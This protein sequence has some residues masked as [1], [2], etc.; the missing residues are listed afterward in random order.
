LSD[1]QLFG[2]WIQHPNRADGQALLGPEVIVEGAQFGEWALVFE[3]KLEGLDF[4]I[5]TLREIGQGI[6]ADLAVSAVGISQQH[7]A[8]RF[9]VTRVGGVID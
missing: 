4:L 7:A 5:G 1:S 9:A 2:Q 3:G 8:I 6:V